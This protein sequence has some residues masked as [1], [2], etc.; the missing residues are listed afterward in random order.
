[1][2]L[3]QV[4]KSHSRDAPTQGCV[5]HSKANSNNNIDMSFHLFD[6]FFVPRIVARVYNHSF[7]EFLFQI[8]EVSLIQPHPQIRKVRLEVKYLT[9]Y[10]YHNRGVLNPGHLAPKI[11]VLIVLQLDLL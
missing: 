9:L 11:P 7:I 8:S 6:S 10:D 1:M 3:L 5:P 2:P 4:R